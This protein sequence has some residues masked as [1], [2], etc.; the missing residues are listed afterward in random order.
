MTVQMAIEIGLG[1]IGFFLSFVVYSLRD[2]LIE[3]VHSIQELN[4]KVAVIIQK[5]EA[6]EEK[7]N[8]L[9]G[10]HDKIYEDINSI[11]IAVAKR[12]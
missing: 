12:E 3:A 1:I 2:V 10:K 6:H 9:E 11:K 7:I 5:T 8:S 4:I